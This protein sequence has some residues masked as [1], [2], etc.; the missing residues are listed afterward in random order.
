MRSDP[1]F[2]DYQAATGPFD[3][4][5]SAEP[6]PEFPTLFCCDYLD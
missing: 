3:Q 2:D 1:G 4:L 6:M 5:V